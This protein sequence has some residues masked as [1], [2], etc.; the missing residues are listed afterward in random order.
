M[1]PISLRLILALAAL[2]SVAGLLLVRDEPTAAATWTLLL[3]TRDDAYTAALDGSDMQ[4]L[5]WQGVPLHNP[6][7]SANGEY[8]ASGGSRDR[9]SPATRFQVFT[10]AGIP[11]W[12]GEQHDY[13]RI[14]RVKV[15]NDGA[16]VGFTAQSA[17][18]AAYDTYLVHQRDNPDP[19]RIQHTYPLPLA[20]APFYE[21]S[22]DGA[23]VYG[24]VVSIQ[25][26]LGYR[27]ETYIFDSRDSA[28]VGVIDG[29]YRPIGASELHGLKFVRTFSRRPPMTYVLDVTRRVDAPLTVGGGVLAW[30]PDG[31]TLLIYREIYNTPTYFTIDL[32][33]GTTT[34]L[35]LDIGT[36]LL[37]GAC[38][39]GERPLGLVAAAP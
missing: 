11:V 22:P 7:C 18:S 23:W 2:F 16:V 15:S 4:P 28:L 3:V 30:S 9:L 25:H 35:M 27:N 6:T 39:L 31:R 10:A 24:Q 26:A 38:F 1:F 12:S 19:I 14:D 29:E 36:T 32:R 8:F 34:P 37:W 5:R 17:A 20:N 33:T 21:L 13:L